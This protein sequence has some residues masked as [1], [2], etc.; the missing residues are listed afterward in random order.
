VANSVHLLRAPPGGTG[1]NTAPQPGSC[2]V[3]PLCVAT[4]T[5]EHIHAASQHHTVVE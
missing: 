4:H 5:S 2:R 3:Y 1:G